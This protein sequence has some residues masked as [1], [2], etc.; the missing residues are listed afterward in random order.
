MG[1]VSHH[2]RS[3]F[4]IMELTVLHAFVCNVRCFV[5]HIRETLLYK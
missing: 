2:L 3:F 1:I 4:G 5:A